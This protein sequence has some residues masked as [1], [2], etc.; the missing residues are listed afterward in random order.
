MR[1]AFGAFAVTL[2]AAGLAEGWP[3][4]RVLPLLP[5]LLRADRLEQALV[6]PVHWVW[7]EEQCRMREY[8]MR[9]GDA[10]AF[11]DSVFFLADFWTVDLRNRVVFVAHALDAARASCLH[12]GGHWR[13][14][15]HAHRSVSLS[16]AS[17]ADNL[18][19]SFRL[20]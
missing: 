9:A 5:R 16:H 20:G 1:R 11:D 18:V 10:I 3:G 14:A 17:L 15:T 8:E 12:S 7:T 6:Q 4:L 19:C 13:R 2:A